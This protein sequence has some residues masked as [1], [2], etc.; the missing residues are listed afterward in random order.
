MIFLDEHIPILLMFVL[1][2]DAESH[3]PTKRKKGQSP[4]YSL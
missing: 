3:F 2:A 4:V 1:D